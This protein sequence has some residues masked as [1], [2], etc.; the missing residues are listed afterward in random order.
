MFGW[1][2]GRQSLCLKQGVEVV[3]VLDLIFGVSGTV[4]PPVPGQCWEDAEGQCAPSWHGH[5][6]VCQG[7]LRC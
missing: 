3:V 2:W 4:S 6:G 1:G 7:S 5:T